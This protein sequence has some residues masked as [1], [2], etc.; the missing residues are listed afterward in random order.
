MNR[1][2]SMHIGPMWEDADERFERGMQVSLPFN[3]QHTDPKQNYGI[4][5]ISLRFYY[6]EI[7]TGRT[8]QFYMHDSWSY[9]AKSRV[10]PFE[11][12]SG[13]DVGYHDTGPHYQNHEPMECDIVKGGECYYDGSSVQ[14][15][16]WLDHFS[17]TN[18]TD[19]WQRLRQRWFDT[20]E[21]RDD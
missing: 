7:I 13:A 17:E 3:R 11:Q 2:N 8:I 21:E 12:Y 16:E 10:R 20:F 19:L 6:R 1:P 9:F 14:A 5:G 4:G 18:F 15:E